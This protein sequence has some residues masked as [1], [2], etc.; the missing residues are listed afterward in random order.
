MNPL[1]IFVSRNEAWQFFS[2]LERKGKVRFHYQSCV[3]FVLDRQEAPPATDWIFFSSPSG[4]RLFLKHYDLTE[5]VKVAVL[6]PGTAAALEGVHL[7]LR[8]NPGHYQVAEAIAEFARGLSPEETV[9]YP[10]SDISLQRLS[11]PLGKNQLLDFPFYKTL[12]QPPVVASD[13]DYLVFSSPSNAEAYLGRHRA[14]TSQ[15]VVA[16]GESTGKSIYALGL[17]GFLISE[18]PR[19][20]A[21]WKAIA[22]D[23]GL[24]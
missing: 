21:I 14:T 24:E 4:L 8:F 23:A 11:K 2:A 1:R 16:I 7:N 19:P 15:R 9:L 12:P 5:N 20:E 6:G 13:A 3:Q 10:R 17:R 22:E 18:E